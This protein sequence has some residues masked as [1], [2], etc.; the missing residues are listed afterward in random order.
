MNL[1]LQTLVAGVLKG[2]LYALIGM[3]MTL[4]MGVMGIIN[5]AH[6]QLMMVA[7]YVTFVCFTYLGID[8]YLS[9]LVVIPILFALG[10]LI[11]K[12]LLNPSLR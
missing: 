4:I 7:M 11:Q 1:F 9:L 10:M 12:Y 8:P 6:G 3:G 5:L 2:G